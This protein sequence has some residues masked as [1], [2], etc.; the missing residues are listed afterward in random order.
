MLTSIWKTCRLW[1]VSCC[2]SNTFSVGGTE[3][4][5]S[6][7][8]AMS[9]WERLCRCHCCFAQELVTRPGE[10]A[11]EALHL[12]GALSQAHPS[13]LS[14]PPYLQ[15]FSAKIL[16]FKQFTSHCTTRRDAWDTAWVSVNHGPFYPGPIGIGKKKTLCF[17][18][19]KS[20]S[21]WLRGIFFLYLRFIPY[22]KGNLYLKK[23]NLQ[24]PCAFLGIHSNKMMNMLSNTDAY[25]GAVWNGEPQQGKWVSDG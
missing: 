9:S 21:K 2:G 22:A 7:T 8:Q 12:S 4:T 24:N 15:R 19:R 16:S 25:H 23:N 5:V 3:A 10:P 6:T 13:S 14:P 1:T 18:C 11:W 20:H 17:I